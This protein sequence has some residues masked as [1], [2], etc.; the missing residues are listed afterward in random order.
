M[1]FVASCP[2]YGSSG[3]GLVREWK[4]RPEQGPGIDF[5]VAQDP[6]YQYGFVGPLSMSKGCDQ[7]LTIY[8]QNL[9]IPGANIEEQ[10]IFRGIIFQE[11][12]KQN[13]SL[14]TSR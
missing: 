7:T 9:Q 2:D 1:Y 10:F 11:K 13:H 8:P 3:S 6:Q 4:L 14:F 12:R 5:G